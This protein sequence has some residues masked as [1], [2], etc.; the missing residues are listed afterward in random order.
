M[1]DLMDPLKFSFPAA[2]PGGGG[3]LPPATATM[4]WANGVKGSYE[5]ALQAHNKL[6]MNVMMLTIFYMIIEKENGINH[7]KGDH[8]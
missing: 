2:I 3:S 1:S 6:V 4:M 5:A 7:S 8:F